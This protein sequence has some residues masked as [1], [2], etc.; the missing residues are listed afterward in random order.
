MG[1]V[2]EVDE[3]TFNEWNPGMAYFLGYL[4]ADGS[5][6]Y[7][8]SIRGK[9]IRASSTDYSLLENLRSY[10]KSKH[11]I[12]SSNRDA[13]SGKQQWLLRIGSKKLYDSLL[14]FGLH[15]RKSLTMEFPQV[16]T[17]Y[18]GA[19]T[20]G[21]F[22]G[23]GC[24]HVEKKETESGSFITKRLRTIFTSGSYNFL[25]TLHSKLCSIN[26]GLNTGRLYT[27]ETVHRLI[28]PTGA[29]VILFNVMYESAEVDT[30][31]HRKFFKFVEYF[32]LQP[33]RTDRDIEKLINKLAQW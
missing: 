23:D 14:T 26:T 8:P 13:T 3:K 11:T 30:M 31:L 18:L 4:F 9:Y 5:M 20:R 24:V 29:S 2:Y 1:V 6:E 7:S 15:P 17:P 21:F 27:T 25:T 19:Y 16:P 10:L 32:R 28:Y 22:D 33:N 12:V